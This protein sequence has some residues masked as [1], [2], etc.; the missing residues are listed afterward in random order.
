MTQFWGKVTG[1]IGGS[2]KKISGDI[3]EKSLQVT[4]SVGEKVE[5]VSVGD[6]W[7][8]VTDKFGWPD[9]TTYSSAWTN[10]WLL[11]ISWTGGTE[12]GMGISIPDLYRPM[13]FPASFVYNGDNAS[14]FYAVYENLDGE[15]VCDDLPYV[16]SW[17]EACFHT[18]Y[19]IGR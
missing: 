1:N 17:S 19:M 10:G 5:I 14:E 4:G 12:S 3:F 18:I 2:T 8:D 11:S 13:V 7:E 15:I 9:S 6:A 16:D